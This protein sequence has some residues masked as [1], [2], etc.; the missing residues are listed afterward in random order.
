MKVAYLVNQYPGISHSFI[1]R[2][3]MALERAGVCVSRFSIRK[4]LNAVIGADDKAEQEKTRYIVGAS[5]GEIF[6][7]TLKT[8]AR[9]PL[10]CANAALEA[11]QLGWNS[12]AGLLRHFM[13]L[14]EALVLADWLKKDG[15]GHLHAHFGTNSAAVALL[16]ARITQVS[17]S[18]TVHGPEEFDK[19]G[20]ISLPRKIK[21]AAF[22]AAV[23]NYG[24][25]QL[26]RLVGPA[27]WNK[28]KIVHCGVETTFFEGQESNAPA[29]PRFVCVG[30]LCEQKGQITLVEAA[31]I[32]KSKGVDFKIVLVG[33]GEMRGEIEQALKDYNVSENFELAGWKSPEDVRTEIKASRAFV[34]PSYAEGLP[35]SIMEALLLGRPVI[36]TYVAGIPE[37][38]T[39]GEN[40]WLAAASDADGLALALEAAARASNEHIDDMGRA[41][42]EKAMARH[43][44]DVEAA[45][46]MECFAEA[47]VA[48]PC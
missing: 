23:S 19:P 34:L 38:V 33:D 9:A 18:F 48:T 30:R 12:E 37:L 4:P 6:T 39:P 22:V 36:S 45:K 44:I 25:S 1:R 47:G 41:G 28:L 46:L 10:R 15:A 5:V 31:S 32:L 14:V 40:G 16:A 20:L 8:I 21:Q 7:A 11:L 17:F 13:Y 35:V 27:F 43:D 26:R 29:A 42:K 24:R 2:E 3:I